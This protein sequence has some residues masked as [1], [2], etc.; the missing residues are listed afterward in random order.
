M[1]FS[2]QW[3]AL[4]R[5]A[6]LAAEQLATGVTTLG[7]A[8]HAYK[9]IYAQAFFSLS[10]GLERLAKLVLV[11]DHAITTKGQWLT[12]SALRKRSHNIAALCDACV[13][14][15]LKY[16][17]DKEFGERPHDEVHDAI[18]G[19]LS[20]FAQHTRYYNLTFLSQG[21]S[22]GVVEPIEAWWDR[23][24][25]LILKRH[26]SDKQRADDENE[27]ELMNALRS[28]HAMVLHHDEAGNQMRSIAELMKRGGATRIVQKYGR[29]YAMQVIR[30]L[31]VLMTELAHQAT[32]THKLEAFFGLDEPFEIFRLPDDFYL[33]RKRWTIYPG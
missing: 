32:Y 29:L 20:A 33:K 8:N 3:H 15:A 12:D 21:H 18:V 9:G 2:P 10:T 25:S 16:V 13:P 4:G 17:K 22:L 31:A 27:A 26:Y 30:W 24:G 11:A 14:I 23:V 7:R 19:T 28:E 1:S 5:E 6:E